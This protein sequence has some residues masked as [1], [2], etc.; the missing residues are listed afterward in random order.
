VVIVMIW[1]RRGAM[2]LAHQLAL[3]AGAALAYGW[4]AFWQHPA[5]GGAGPSVRVGNAIFLAA[6]TGLIW[7]AARRVSVSR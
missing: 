1:S 2:T 5:V 3:G 7:F 6:A 4:H